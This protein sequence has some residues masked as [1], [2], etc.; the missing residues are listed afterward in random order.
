[1]PATRLTLVDAP[2]IKK[3]ARQAGVWGCPG[4]GP[5]SP[6]RGARWAFRR[7]NCFSK[8]CHAWRP[9]TPTE[10]SCRR[11]DWDTAEATPLLI[12]CGNAHCVVGIGVCSTG[13]ATIALEAVLLVVH[14]AGS[15][16]AIVSGLL[17][18]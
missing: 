15:H 14:Q 3:S 6:R 12:Q 1:M 2:C 17:N 10:P 9:G 8:R 5:T 11:R 7:G 13:S 16:A 18:P 4:P